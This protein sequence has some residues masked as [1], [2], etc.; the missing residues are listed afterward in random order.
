MVQL[1]LDI[2]GQADLRRFAATDGEQSLR[3]ASVDWRAVKLYQ[4][5]G[6]NS[7]GFHVCFSMKMVPNFGIY[8]W[9][10]YMFQRISGISCWFLSTVSAYVCIL[11]LRLKWVGPKPPT[12]NPTMKNRLWLAVAVRLLAA[13]E[14]E[15]PELTRSVGTWNINLSVWMHGWIGWGHKIDIDVGVYI[16]IFI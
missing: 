13:V 4:L 7:W 12:P 5:I 16:Y 6:R 1:R 15:D 8:Q 11:V 14:L 3:G 9:C 2:E 10:W